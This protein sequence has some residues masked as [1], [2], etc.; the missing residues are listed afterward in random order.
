MQPGRLTLDAETRFI[1]G[2]V[3]DMAGLRL[4][5]SMSYGVALEREVSS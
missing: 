3:S 1:Q 2:C 4:E 5:F